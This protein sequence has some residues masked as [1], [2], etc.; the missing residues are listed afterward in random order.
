[1][2]IIVF[3]GIFMTL[4][5]NL[6]IKMSLNLLIFSVVLIKIFKDEKKLLN[7]NKLLVLLLIILFAFFIHG[8]D[9]LSRLFNNL[10]FLIL[11][12]FI[13]LNSK[14]LTKDFFKAIEISFWVTAPVFLYD[15]SNF[16]AAT[17][18]NLGG[19]Y[20][21]GLAFVYAF[22]FFYCTQKTDTLVSKLKMVFSL[23]MLILVQSTGAYLVAIALFLSSLML[24]VDFFRSKF[25][26]LIL[27]FYTI[28]MVLMAYIVFTFGTFYS[29]GGI[30]FLDV[31]G[32]PSFLK[33]KVIVLGPLF[34]DILSQNIF[35]YFLG[36]NDE[37]LNTSGSDFEYTLMFLEIFYKFGLFGILFFLI[38]LVRN[39]NRFIQFEEHDLLWV[40]LYGIFVFIFGAGLF[41]PTSYTLA[42]WM[43]VFVS[44]DNYQIKKRVD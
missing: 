34:S 12:Y 3:Q 2:S 9:S 6:A 40:F 36:I 5:Q 38:A 23:L 21:N 1:M 26:L 7:L 25:S 39:I 13:S 30:G 44:L 10:F 33:T 28:S 8:A 17:S 42:F 43:T 16:I 15:Y 27:I 41:T 32:F 11:F 19:M 31:S 22:Y 20:L 35:S 37:K 14:D 29:F 18:T 4:S 24:K